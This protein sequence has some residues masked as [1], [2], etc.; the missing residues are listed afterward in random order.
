MLANIQGMVKNATYSPEAEK[1]SEKEKQSQE[2]IYS[3]FKDRLDYSKKLLIEEYTKLK[4]DEISINVLKNDYDYILKE[5]NDNIVW[6]R[7]NKNESSDKLKSKFES[8][9]ESPYATNISYRYNFLLTIINFKKDSK[10]LEKPKKGKDGKDTPH[11]PYEKEYISVINKETDIAYKWAIKNRLN[12]D[13][14]EYEQQRNNLNE[15]LGQKGQSELQTKVKKET[16]ENNTFDSWR[17]AKTTLST[18]GILLLVGLILGFGL[19]GSSLAMNLNAYRSFYFRLFYMI[20]GFMFSF[21]VISY[22]FLY[23]K[24]WNGKSIPHFSLFPLIEGCFTSPFL[25]DYFGWLTFQPSDEVLA[26]LA[27]GF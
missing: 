18:T 9:F 7:N 1:A 5:L 4:D 21:F 12:A 8:L 11:T 25:A 19:V 20:Y 14:A 23:V 15:L 24:W 10:T 17:L 16:V 3:T 6:L 13:Y 26:Y 27:N 2:K 22:C